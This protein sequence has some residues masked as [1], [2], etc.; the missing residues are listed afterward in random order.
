MEGGAAAPN[1]ER[2]YLAYF[3]DKVPLEF[4]DTTARRRTW[5]AKHR[6]RCRAIHASSA[7]LVAGERLRVQDIEATNV[8]ERE[9]CGRIRAPNC[10]LAFCG[11]R[12]VRTRRTAQA[13]HC[14]RLNFSPVEVPAI[15]WSDT[16]TAASSAS[17]SIRIASCVRTM[18]SES[19]TMVRH[20]R[21]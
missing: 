2:T 19:A 6:G 8:T 18:V 21:H 10:R 9:R 4:V 15:S 17:T 13:E 11:A 14:T 16:T 1:C 5:C 7:Q 3:F 12:L 20:T